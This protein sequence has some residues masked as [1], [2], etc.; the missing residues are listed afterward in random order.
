M[1]DDFLKKPCVLD[2]LSL[3]YLTRYAGNRIHSDEAKAELRLRAIMQDVC[4]ARLESR[5]SMDR[6]AIK[7]GGLQTH[8]PDISDV[9]S[10]FVTMCKQAHR[11][12][13]ELVA[14]EIVCRPTSPNPNP[15]SSRL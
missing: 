9:S 10:S 13:Q 3:D 5:W 4:I 14:Q 11:S 8:A 1:R 6:R 15:A 7:L 12:S 2:A